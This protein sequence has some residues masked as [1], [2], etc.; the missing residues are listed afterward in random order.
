MH[1]LS[2]IFRTILNVMYV[3][4]SEILKTE[5]RDLSL[6]KAILLPRWTELAPGGRTML[7]PGEVTHF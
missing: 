5:M 1:T 3:Y 6:V 2:N 7:Q 4:M